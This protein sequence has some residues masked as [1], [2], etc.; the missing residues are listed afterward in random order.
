MNTKP[1]MNIIIAIVSLAI[2]WNF[3]ASQVQADEL[4]VADGAKL[5][6]DNC[7]RCHNPKP[8]ESYT[9]AEW[10]VIMPHMREKAHL[11]GTESR[12][13]ERFIASTLTADVQQSHRVDAPSKPGSADGK[14]LFAQNGCGGC[15][16]I[17]GSGGT[18]GPDLEKALSTRGAQYMVEKILNPAIGNPASTM[19][20]F[21]VTE[22]EASAIVEYIRL[23]STKTD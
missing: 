21:P 5:Y 8:A 4:S 3:A 20:K 15:H 9:A 1:R 17:S 11:T 6:N 2:S 16:Q 12:A 14:A 22:S 19:P 10:S 18:M 13:I 7:A 23:Q